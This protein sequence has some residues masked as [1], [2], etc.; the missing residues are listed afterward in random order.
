MKLGLRSLAVGSLVALF[1]SVLAACSTQGPVDGTDLEGASESGD[2]SQELSGGVPIGTTLVTTSALNLRAGASTSD[3][4]L[5]VIPQGAS[6]VTVNRTTPVNGF[7]NVKHSGVEGWA[8]G[9]Y[10]KT[11]G[12][13]GGG[14]G[15]AAADQAIARAQD[16]VGFSYWWGHGRIM[17][18]GPTS[19]TK[20]S[21]SGSCPSCSHSG[22]Y[23]ADCSGYAAKVWVVPGNNS[24]LDV[25]S[26][27][28]STVNF[29]NDTTF[30]KVIAKGNLKKGDALVYNSNGEGHIYIYD[31]GD[32]W[33]S[34]WAYEAK[35]CSYGIVHDLRTASSAYKAIRRDGY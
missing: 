23:G 7:Y 32:P 13:G 33:G 5:H 31:S 18:T 27:P 10:L 14:G 15:S 28:Y 19:Q 34:H 12:G 30:W 3:K 24:Q 1:V 25:D 6:V 22:S 17:S 9:A 26:H 20:G 16:G 35:G 8:Y 29:Y 4:I 21:C 2:L 11:N